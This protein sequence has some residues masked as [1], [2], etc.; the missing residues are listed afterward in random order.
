MDSS[1]IPEL[2]RYDALLSITNRKNNG[3]FKVKVMKT[4]EGC[5]EKWGNRFCGDDSG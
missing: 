2:K 1:T 3:E 5:S 4:C